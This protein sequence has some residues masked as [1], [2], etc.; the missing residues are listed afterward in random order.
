[1]LLVRSLLHKR[2]DAAST[3]RHTELEP[4]RNWTRTLR[5]QAPFYVIAGAHVAAKLYYLRYIFALRYPFVQAVYA[6]SF[7]SRAGL[8]HISFYL[9][10]GVDAFCTLI[11]ADAR[12]LGVGV[13]IAAT[14]S[15]AT[16]CV[17]AARRRAAPRTLPVG[18][19]PIPVSAPRASYRESRTARSAQSRAA[20]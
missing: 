8:R 18:F 4:Q 7:G 5:Q 3:Q 16:A 15:I 6:L 14:P 20:S 13:V 10:F 11:T 1:L 17:I 9:P 12:A 2:R 19:H